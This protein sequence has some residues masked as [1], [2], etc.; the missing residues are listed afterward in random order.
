[1][2]RW[3]GIVLFLVVALALAGCGADNTGNDEGGQATEDPADVAAAE[4]IYSNNCASCHGGNLEGA[5]GPG[6]ETIGSK[7]SESD[8]ADIIENG[9][10]QMPA[11]TQVSSAERDELAGWLAD[12][13]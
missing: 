13:K 1:M 4:Q 7:L 9:Q 3:K 12:K 11:Q 6:L 10:G 5:M 2:M 8:I